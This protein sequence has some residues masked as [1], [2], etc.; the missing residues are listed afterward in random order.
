MPL[1]VRVHGDSYP[2]PG[3][4]TYDLGYIVFTKISGEYE[5]STLSEFP[6]LMAP[7][8]FTRV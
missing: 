1:S 2:V 3:N 4:A 5:T 6:S 7:L 8:R